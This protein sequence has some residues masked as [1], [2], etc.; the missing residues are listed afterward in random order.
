MPISPVERADEYPARVSIDARV[1][2][3]ISGAIEID[4]QRRTSFWLGSHGSSR[5]GSRTRSAE[6]SDVYGAPSSRATRP[7]PACESVDDRGSARAAGHSHTWSRLGLSETRVH[8]P[9][10]R[11][12][13]SHSSRPARPRATPCGA[14]NMMTREVLVT[15]RRQRPRMEH[16]PSAVAQLAGVRP[17]GARQRAQHADATERPPAPPGRHCPAALFVATDCADG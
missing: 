1:P 2:E 10:P 4:L 5:R 14:P 6:S 3:S 16:A 15:A 17:R 13:T 9:S 7:T 11:S 8:A 12:E